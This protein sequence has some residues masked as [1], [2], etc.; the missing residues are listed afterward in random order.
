ME[1][2]AQAEQHTAKSSEME[3]TENSPN[4]E[5]LASMELLLISH[6]SLSSAHPHHR[7]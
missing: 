1:S 4:A 5:I 2:D 3:P 6:K 7:V